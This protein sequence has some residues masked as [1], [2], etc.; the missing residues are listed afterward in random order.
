MTEHP[1]SAPKGD[2]KLPGVGEVPKKWFIIVGG[3]SLLVIVYVMY[4]RSKT[5][6]HHRG[7]GHGYVVADRAGVH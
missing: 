6:R 4:R 2:V 5:P 1:V 3:G 7:G